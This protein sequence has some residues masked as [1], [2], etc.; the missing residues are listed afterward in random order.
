MGRWPRS[1]GL[2][3]GLAVALLAQGACALTTPTVQGAWPPAVARA[4]LARLPLVEVTVG[5]VPGAQLSNDTF[6]VV[7]SGDGGWGAPNKGMSNRLT[8]GG[9]PVVGV[10][11]ARYLLL[12]KSADQTA[13]DLTAIIDHYSAA[14]GRSR[15]ILV[16]YSFGADALPLIAE[17]LPP[18]ELAKVRLIALISPTD[19]GDLAFRGVSWWDGRWPSAKPLTPALRTLAGIPMICLYGAHDPR[20][21]CQRFPVEIIRPIPFP[22]NHRYKG[23]LDEVGDTILTAAG[24]PAP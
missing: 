4:R 13:A 14:W 2:R 15:V 3:I 11:A 20:A 12:R 1:W 5:S 23:E 18:A 24:L 17:Q 6:A 22:G 8:A 21:A 10:S 19:F 9:V 7:Y 16:G